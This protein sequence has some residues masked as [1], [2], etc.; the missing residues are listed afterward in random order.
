MSWTRS[1]EQWDRSCERP[2]NYENDNARH[3][4]DL[5][6]DHFG[7]EDRDENPYEDDDE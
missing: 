6:R 1:T 3:E 4:K 2:N 7:A 5:Y